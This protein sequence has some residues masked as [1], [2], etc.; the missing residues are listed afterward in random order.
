MKNILKSVKRLKVKHR[1]ALWI[2]QDLDIWFFDVEADHWRF[3]STYE[4]GVTHMTGIGV[5]SAPVL[6]FGPYSRLYKF[7]A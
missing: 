3:M 7:D 6:S 2:D 5:L 4:T 1:N